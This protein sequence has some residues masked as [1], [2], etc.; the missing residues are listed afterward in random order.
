MPHNL[1]CTNISVQDRHP[2]S[3]VK[4]KN[5]Q[6]FQNFLQRIVGQSCAYA[7]AAMLWLWEDKKAEASSLD[8]P[9]INGYV[10]KSYPILWNTTAMENI[11]LDKFPKWNTIIASTQ[12][13]QNYWEDLWPKDLYR[14]NN[15][16]DLLAKVQKIG[17]SVKYITDAEL[18]GVRDKW[19]N[20]SEFM[21]KGGDCEDFAIAKFMMLR[22][23]GVPNEA[24]RLVV[25]MDKKTNE[26]HAVLVVYPTFAGRFAEMSEPKL[27]DNRDRNVMKTSRLDGRYQPIYS[28]NE[29]SWWVHQSIQSQT[30][31]LAAR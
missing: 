13:T 25:L 27:L 9:V 31:N 17:N 11:G 26:A 2:Q 18:Y 15:L 12:Q 29:T 24:L 20:P 23:A 22:S 6:G 5:P 7:M 14:Q 4:P 10:E 28:L 16:D 8:A 19:A 3:L 21:S 30:I 1:Y